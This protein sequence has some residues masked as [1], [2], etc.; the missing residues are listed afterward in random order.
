MAFLRSTSGVD[1]DAELHG[2]QVFL[3]HPV[4]GDYSAWAQLRA[5]SRQH[6]TV[7]EPQWTR[8]ELTRS[9][10][11]RRLR[12]YQRELRDDQGYAFLIF[13]HADGALVGGLGLSNIRRG[14]AQAASLGYWIGAPHVRCGHMTDAVKA[15]L[16]FAFA[17][18]GLHRLEAAC[19]PHN[20]P[21]R[22]VLEK[23]G[24]GREGLARRYLKI[25]GVWQ[26]H[27]LFALLQD[28]AQG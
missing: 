26:D 5:V 28:D 15:C 23:V 4:M 21:S 8:D 12:Q 17:T 7:W 25:N 20:A 9:A 16:P 3:R 18:L 14:V 22:R 6:L 11:R 24:F 19:L 1:P 13:R 10:Y 27:D 2:R